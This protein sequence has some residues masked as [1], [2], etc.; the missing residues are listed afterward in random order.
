MDTR[1]WVPM[2]WPCG[3]LE[4]ERGQRREGFG[5]DERETLEQWLDPRML[6]HLE[7]TPI[8]CLVVAWTGGSG[9]DEEQHRA[10][11]PLIA[12]ARGA[13]L[14]VVGAVVPGADLRPAARAADSAGLQALA[15]VSPEPLEGF[16]VLRFGEPGVTG[17][18]P[19]GF[20]GVD[21]LPWPGLKVE[22]STSADAV[23]GPTGP[24]WIDSNAWF[25]RLA[26]EILRPETTWLSYEPPEAGMGEPDAAYVQ[27]IADAEV[28]GA[29][30]M[31]SLDPGLRRDLARGVGP[32]LETWSRIVQA[33]EFFEAHRAWDRCRPV[34]QLGVV[35]DFSGPNEW[36]SFEVLNLLSRY[37]R[38]HRAIPRSAGQAPAA[39]D[40]D[41]FRGPTPP[42]AGCLAG[43]KAVVYVDERPPE[44]ELLQ[45]LYAFAE[46]GGTLITPPGWEQRGEPLS[47]SSFSRFHL[48]RYGQGRLA[49][50]REEISDPYRL[51]QDAQALT[52]HRH[53]LVRV[54][55]PGTGR[56]AY[57]RSEDGRSAVLHLFPYSRYSF[58]THV[59]VWFREPWRTAATWEVGSAG[60]QT[61]ER[62][63]TETGVEFLL[64]PEPEVV[65]PRSTNS[66]VFVR[67]A[68]AYRAVELSR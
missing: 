47:R 51:A 21:G 53:D 33:V 16:P 28:Y 10:L 67:P 42:A 36:L 52:S 54:F 2:R 56:F 7:G 29:R 40:A 65:R 13:G 39:T 15:T 45:Q 27:A 11:A 68:A 43:L 59:S 38:L 3:P 35:S 24:P 62:T 46:A 66:D 30:W 12:A 18:A 50:A 55:N 32:G 20:L 31:V 37:S 60:P 64:P 63:V 4:I 6:G 61:T 8:N 23:S 9:A 34:G 44:T 49:V 19:G 26:H 17:R 48:S 1:H 58:E 5:T 25:V 14:T 22:L 57:S 41:S